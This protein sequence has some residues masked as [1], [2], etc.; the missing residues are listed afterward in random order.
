MYFSFMRTG[1]CDLFPKTV[2]IVIVLD[3]FIT[4]L[5]RKVRKR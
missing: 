5:V 4:I 3:T 2:T 1:Y